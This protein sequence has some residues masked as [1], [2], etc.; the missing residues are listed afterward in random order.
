MKS[1]AYEGLWKYSGATNVVGVTIT[2]PPPVG[3]RSGE[4]SGRF[5]I[6]NSVT[7]PY[8]RIYSLLNDA[9]Y[10]FSDLFR[11]T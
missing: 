9:T 4:I 11:R 6:E 10:I 8:I 1:V 7:F 3:K 5:V 2:S